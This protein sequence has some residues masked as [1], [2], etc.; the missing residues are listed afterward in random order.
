[1]AARDNGVP[2]TPDWLN[3]RLRNFQ[4][5][6][7]GPAIAV[8]LSGG[9]DSTALTWLLA[10]WAHRSGKIL[11]ALTVD[12]G[13]RPEA[14]REARQV[15]EWVLPWKDKWGLHHE[16]L[17]WD[18]PKP[19]TGLQEAAREA[20]YRLM[21]EY[22]HRHGIRVLFL[23]HHTDDQA[24][25][26][27]FRLAK[28]SGLDG[29]AG[30]A[31][32]QDACGMVLLRPLLDRSHHDLLE[33]CRTHNLNWIEDKS[34]VSDRYFRGR[35]RQGIHFLEAEGL[36]ATRL[37]KL[38]ARLRRARSA[39]DY[40]TDLAWKNCIAEKEINRIVFSFDQ[41]QSCPDDIRIRLLSRAI[42]SFRPDQAYPVRLEDV[43]SLA[44]RL[45]PRD[46]SFK[47]ATLGGCLIRLEGKNARLSIQP[48]KSRTNLRPEAG[49]GPD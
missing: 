34:N 6:L 10:Q 16:I 18:G 30:M 37:S 4:N 11:H 35:I 43:E 36:S 27:L 29:L 28:G 42:G 25:T 7:T 19:E 1:M 46:G 49:R 12:H 23:A 48:E 13:L 3:G 47:A 8:A 5:D 38:A 2:L 44:T 45:T 33:T 26:L 15:A 21:A 31:E 39:L 20:R 22:C 14:A 24:E 40:Y 41:F 17:V 9:G 32:R